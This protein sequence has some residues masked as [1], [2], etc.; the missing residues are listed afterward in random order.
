MKPSKEI[1][2]E[3]QNVKDE[4][5]QLINS[6]TPEQINIVPFEGS[7]TGG[8]VVD[9]ILKSVSTISKA[10]YGAAT[11]TVRNPDEKVAMVQ[12]LFLDF[13]RKLNSP[14]FII[15]PKM[16]HQKEA[17]TEAVAHAMANIM[18]AVETFDPSATCLD[19]ELPKAGKFT[20][21][22]WYH[23]IIYHT[24]R[25]NYQLNNIFQKLKNSSTQVQ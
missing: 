17:L 12:A 14:D 15:P 13:S 10:I 19:F 24:T 21:Y 22:E 1:I 9:H 23:F 20:R 3:I 18:G 16:D 6:F 25:H 8:Q 2:A 11:V 7:W 4:L 5:L